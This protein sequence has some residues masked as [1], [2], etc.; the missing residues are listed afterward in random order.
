MADTMPGKAEA[1]GRTSPQTGCFSPSGQSCG[2]GQEDK[3]YYTLLA[4]DISQQNFMGPFQQVQEFEARTRNRPATSP[5]PSQNTMIYIHI[6][7]C[8]A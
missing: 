6:Y 4:P 8:R 1:D 3:T 5:H 7:I 2:P